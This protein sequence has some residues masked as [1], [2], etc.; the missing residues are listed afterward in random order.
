[1][2]KTTEEEKPIKQQVISGRR[3]FIVHVSSGS[4]SKSISVASSSQVSTPRGG[5][6]STNFIISGHDPTIR[7]P[8]FRG[9]GSEDPKKNLFICENIWGAKNITYEDKKGCIVGN[10]IQRPRTRLVHGSHSK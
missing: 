3:I 8:K 7:L 1:V 4:S 9:E 6:S 10:H 5:C 2:T